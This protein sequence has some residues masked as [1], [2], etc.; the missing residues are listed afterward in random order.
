MKI[1]FRSVDDPSATFEV[2]IE[3]DRY[4]YLVDE[5]ERRNITTDE[6]IGQVITAYSRTLVMLVSARAAVD[7][8][9]EAH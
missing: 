1:E 8:G 3:D 4:R 7:S 9:R 2:D 6:L 5:A